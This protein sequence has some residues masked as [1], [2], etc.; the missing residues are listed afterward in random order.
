MVHADLAARNLLLAEH[1]VVKICDFGLA[2]NLY[3]YTNYH[4]KSDVSYY[5]MSKYDD[6]E[7]F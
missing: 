7:L 2:R 1:N 5:E 3:Q 6:T 4:K